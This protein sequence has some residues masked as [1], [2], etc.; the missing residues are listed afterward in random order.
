MTTSVSFFGTR[1]DGKQSSLL[2]FSYPNPWTSA[3]L[4]RAIPPLLV[5]RV[6][7]YVLGAS[8]NFPSWGPME[9][10]TAVI[11][12]IEDPQAELESERYIQY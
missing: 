9:P 7:H 5:W 11:R 3:I 1:E 8:H 10:Y 2:S 4:E 6:C 12:N